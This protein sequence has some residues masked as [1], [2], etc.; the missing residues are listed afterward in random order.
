MAVGASV[1]AE[2]ERQALIVAT[3]CPRGPEV[4]KQY[5]KADS[6]APVSVLVS[7][8]VSDDYEMLAY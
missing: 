3:R 5:E 8:P 1:R 7:I 2:H 6:L 4:V